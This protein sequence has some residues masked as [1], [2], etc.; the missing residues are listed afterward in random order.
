MWNKF[1]KNNG[2]NPFKRLKPFDF[3]IYEKLKVSTK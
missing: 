2:L 3:K 1:I